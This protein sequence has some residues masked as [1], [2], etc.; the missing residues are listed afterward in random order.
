MAALD[1]AGKV[2]RTLLQHFEDFLGHLIAFYVFL[3]ERYQT[4]R[5]IF[6]AEYVARI[7]RAHE[8]ILKKLLRAGIDVCARIDQNENI[9]F[10]RKHC[11]DAGTIDAW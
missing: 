1:V 3:A 6:V 7:N 10:C 9:R 4:D 8:C 2:E 5:R 11:C